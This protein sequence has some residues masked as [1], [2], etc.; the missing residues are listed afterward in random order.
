[1]MNYCFTLIYASEKR[2]NMHPSLARAKQLSSLMQKF[3]VLAAVVTI[4]A[5]AYVAV[6]AATDGGWVSQVLFYRLGLADALPV[7]G[8]QAFGLI[9]LFCIQIAV[10]LAALHA[11]WHLFGLIAASEGINMDIARWL[12]RAGI[13]FAVSSA[14]MVA[15]QPLYSVI[16]T[17]GAEPGRRVVSVGFGSDELMAFLMAAVLIVLGHVMMLAADISD[18]NRQIV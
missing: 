11:L 2:I 5:A 4:A 3:L 14:L 15:F 10:F 12:R 13:F 8:A 16:G 17:L 6:K 9:V 18:D 1:M 7:S